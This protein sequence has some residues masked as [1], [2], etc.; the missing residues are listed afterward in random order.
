[1]GR[2]W[3]VVEEIWMVGYFLS[4]EGGFLFREE[5]DIVNGVVI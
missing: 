1:M 2:T 5:V 4:L 3:G